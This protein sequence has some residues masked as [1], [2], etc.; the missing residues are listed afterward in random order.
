MIET[1]NKLNE[2]ATISDKRDDDDDEELKTQFN[3]TEVRIKIEPL[4]LSQ[5]DDFYNDDMNV[6][7]SSE[8]ED[9]KPE[10][11]KV[12]P[13]VTVKVIKK[14][15]VSRINVPHKSKKKKKFERNFKCNICG[16]RHITEKTLENHMMYNHVDQLTKEELIRIKKRNK[17]E[18]MKICYICGQVTDQLNKHVKKV[19][20]NIRKF[21][22]DH[23]SYSSFKRFDM[24]SHVLKHRKQPNKEFMC[25]TCG[26]EFIRKTSLRQHWKDFHSN[27]DPF[28]CSFCSQQFKTQ[29]LMKKHIKW[30]HE[31][32]NK[33][34]CPDCEKEIAISCLEKH[35]M[36][37]P[38][39]FGQQFVCMEC[40]KEFKNKRCLTFHRQT[41]NKKVFICEFT[42][43]GKSYATLNQ[44]SSHQ[45]RH[46]D[47]KNIKCPYPDCDKSYF[48][49]QN[50]RIHIANMHTTNRSKCPVNDCKYNSA[51]Y[52]Y[53]RDHLLRHKGL[54]VDLQQEYFM[55]IKKMNLVS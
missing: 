53:M 27:L 43:C 45:K 39:T 24:T 17:D 51:S 34:K 38:E 46:T 37:D 15:E 13:D 55:L 14:A 44:L 22:C 20:L 18:R 19:H 48:K 3:L 49:Q 52:N 54:N 33:T 6:S 10:E 2:I 47:Q 7:Y 4:D 42:D 21:F 32:D 36:T 16:V 23:C 30:R 25:D 26:T 29:T 1:Q 40:G 12:E 9:T 35:I 41:H 11:I 31:G 5:A 50:L 28:V 8:E